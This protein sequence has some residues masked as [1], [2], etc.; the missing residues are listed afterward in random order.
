MF[1][2]WTFIIS[3][4]G[5]GLLYL[6]LNFVVFPLYWV[7]LLPGTKYQTHPTA[8]HK[9]FLSL[10]NSIL[11]SSCFLT[12]YILPAIKHSDLDLV[13]LQQYFQQVQ[14]VNTP[15]KNEV[16]L[17]CLYFG[18][19]LVDSIWLTYTKCRDAFQIFHHIFT[20]LVFMT[21][22]VQEAHGFETTFLMTL[23]EISSIVLNT[24]GIAKFY[25]FYKKVHS[26][27]NIV[28]T[29]I[30]FATRI[31]V[32][33]VFGLFLA[34]SS[35]TRLDTWFWYSGLGVIN[36]TFFKRAIKLVQKNLKK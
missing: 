2:Y 19:I 8:Y 1:D 7:K 22:L 3:F 23:M 34:R 21:T 24:R 10:T 25:S 30:F 36:F 27:F 29:G 31:L 14:Q 18:Y 9:Y 15:T 26:Y 5:Y 35:L 6:Q 16:W 17:I 28:Y 32:F 12:F 13:K 11:M 20:I 4:F 33:T